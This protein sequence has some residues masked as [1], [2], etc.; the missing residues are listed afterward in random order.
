MDRNIVYP[1]SIPLDSD[2]L[3]LNRNTLVALGALMQAVFGQSPLVDGLAVTP[4][5]PPSLGVLIAPGSIT[6]YDALD[7]SAYG[8]IAADGND[9][10]VKMGINVA[11]TVVA[12]GVPGSVGQSI[13][14]LVEASFQESDVSPVVLPYFNAAAPDQPWLGPNNSGQAQATQRIQRVA[15]RAR[16]GAAAPTGT[17]VP[18]PT[19]PGWY[20][21]ATVTTNYA[22]T[23]IDATSIASSS[24]S[25]IIPFRLPSLRPGFSSIVSY[26][27]SGVFIVPAAVT[28]AKVRIIGGGG[29][30]GG[31][32][33][34]G[35]GGG[36]GGG[37]YAESIIPVNPGQTIAINV[38]AGG[39]GGSNGSGTAVG[40]AGQNG[41]TS[42]FGT[43]MAATGGIGGGGSLVGG[44]G[45]SGP[46]GVGQGGTVTMAGGAGNAG[47]SAGPNGFGGHGAPAAC[48]GGGGA[49]SSGLPSSGAVPG[50]GGAGGGGNFSGAPGGAGLVI[51]E[52]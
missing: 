11:A 38:G 7:N 19:A 27:N 34:Q 37:G 30:G 2:I 42:S 9:Y 20:P 39:A 22:Q 8:S 17:A 14:S 5:Q 16:V 4:T 35:G 52:Y 10:L 46:G 24:L 32:T 41:G 18:P 45:N 28:R 23:E 21:V 25:P 31:N 6:T 44:Q 50:G 47:F 15:L 26:S 13:V 3:N 1:G 29:G 51:I 40:N 48:G 12:I 33:T 36:G 43:A 49:A